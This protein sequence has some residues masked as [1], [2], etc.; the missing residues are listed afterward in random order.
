MTLRLSTSAKRPPS[1]PARRAL[2]GSVSAGACWPKSNGSALGQP[3]KALAHLPHRQF[4]FLRRQENEVVNV[5]AEAPAGLQRR[6]QVG[7]VG[8]VL[9]AVNREAFDRL[10][11][12]LVDEE[13][14]VAEVSEV[15]AGPLQSTGRQP[16]VD[17]HQHAWPTA[18]DGFDCTIEHRLL[19]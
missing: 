11:V 8:R 19:M 9:H 4:R 2:T 18:P 6:R 5:A 1:R 3:M 12:A 14:A 16:V 15:A 7:Q 17:L 10:D 13:A